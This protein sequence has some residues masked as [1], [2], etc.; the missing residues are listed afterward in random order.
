MFCQMADAPATKITVKNPLKKQN[1]VIFMSDKC[2][3]KK[4]IFI[5]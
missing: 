5:Q 1:C 2:M 4:K 3:S